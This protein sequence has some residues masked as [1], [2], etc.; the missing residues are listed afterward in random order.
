LFL[1]ATV[2]PAL[3]LG[4]LAWL[5]L[6]RLD[7]QSAQ[8]ALEHAAARVGA[9]LHQRLDD[10]TNQ[11]PGLLQATSAA[12]P[13]DSVLL[14]IAANRVE[15]QPAHRLLYLPGAASDQPPSGSTLDAATAFEASGRLS[16][17]IN[18]FR[19]ASLVADPAVRAAALLGLARCQRKAGRWREALQTYDRLAALGA[20]PVL[21]APAA[22]VARR[23]Q[24]AVLANAG[25]PS[26]EAHARLLYADLL[27]PAWRLDRD[28]FDYYT[29][30]VRSWLPP[31]SAP[32]PDAG[33]LALTDLV[34]QVVL[35]M[36][37]PHRAER[38]WLSAWSHDRDGDALEPVLVVWHRSPSGTAV[39]MAGRS[40]F[41]RSAASWAA[42]NLSALVT[43]AGGVVLGDSSRNAAPSVLVP[44]DGLPWTLR[45]TYADASKIASPFARG[46]RAV[47]G[48]FLSAGLLLLVGGALVARG[49]ARE[50]AVARL[51]NDFVAAVSHEFRSP[52]TSMQ[53]LIEMLADGVVRDDSR[54]QHYYEVLNHETSRLR[55][56]VEDLLNFGRM[57]AGR[58]DYRLER[59][60]AMALVREIGRPP[61]RDAAAAGRLQLD[62][63]ETPAWIAAD[64]EALTRALRNLIENAEKYSDAARPVY[65]RARTHGHDVW[66]S[67]QDHGPGIPAHEQKRIFTKFY[68][69]ADAS[70]SGVKGTGLGLATVQH[71]ARAHRGRV[72]VES[73]PGRGST[74]TIVVPAQ[75][76]S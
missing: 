66:L 61:G 73:A 62:A 4:R 17:A 74:F 44:A 56:L 36:D 64:R 42:D 20:F 26:L 46:R 32:L 24:C 51:Q 2:L 67:V 21:G 5:G 59:L 10:L 9:D 14:S 18:A 6:E 15:A 39:L 72:L 45:V 13:D 71:I 3:V 70:R 22:L 16:A 54:R 50:L 41:E 8:D 49:L 31:R 65:L 12:M 76:A 60:D 68:R 55:G 19:R 52:L 33:R 11:L 37:E 25:D 69:G 40:W 57:E 7:Q 58:T 48:G 75:V 23:A 34:D 35:W 53:H 28:T 30:D 1:A 38:G 29:A 43:D 27:T 47:L 63:P